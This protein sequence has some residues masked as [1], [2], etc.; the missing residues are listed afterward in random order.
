MSAPRTLTFFGGAATATGSMMLLEAAGARV[1]LDA[2]LFQGNVA[3]TDEQNRDLPLDPGKVDAILLSHGGLAASGRAP[4]M[5]RHGYHGP[6]YATPATRDCT[7]V[8]LAEA[9]LELARRENPLFGLSEVFATQAL[10][11][12]QP[13]HRPYYLR[14]NLVFEFADAGHML[15]SASIE[16]RTGEGGTHR[17]I[18]SGSVGRPGA[19]L[20]RD[21]APPLGH[22]DT[23]IVG[24]PFAHLRHPMF[25]DARQCLGTIINDA[26]TRNGLIIVP[27]ASV[28]PVQELIR[29][30][31][32]L[33]HRGVIPAVPIWLDTPTPVSL[34]TLLRLHPEI[35]QVDAQSYL[36]GPGAFD[37]SLM[38]SVTSSAE[39]QQIDQLQGPAIIVAPNETCD[40]GRSAEHLR[41]RLGDARHTFLFLSF[42]EDGS[43]GRLLQDGA[44]SVDIDGERVQRRAAI[45]TMTAFSGFADG[46]EMR[47]WVRSLGGPIKRAFVVHGDD[48]AVSMMVTILREE[49]VRDVIVPRQGE[50]FPF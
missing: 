13:Y 30:V 10:F 41:H 46:E 29:A 2:G 22:V 5:V 25:S 3:Q 44:E 28:G 48:L 21:A 31:Q 40:A 17:I 47:A 24:S 50:S 36:G 14:R 42:Q 12:A 4:Q 1:L 19:P 45:E 9:A 15:G 8:L 32:D 38:H 16:L 43:V 35:M 49:G 11:V 26:V 18:Y 23:L 33:H 7:A 37:A 39:R 27:A 34:P 6:I 20:I